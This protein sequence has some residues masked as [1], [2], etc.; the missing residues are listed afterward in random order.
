MVDDV[1]V[2]DSDDN[3]NASRPRAEIVGTTVSY[4]MDSKVPVTYSYEILGIAIAVVGMVVVVA[5][6]AVVVRC[7]IVV[8]LHVGIGSFRYYSPQ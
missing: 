6:I 2:D 5:A 1:N 7:R 3:R 8:P 4:L